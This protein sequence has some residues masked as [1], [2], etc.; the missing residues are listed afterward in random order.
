M[1]FSYAPFSI[2]C[3]QSLKLHIVEVIK[4]FAFPLAFAQAYGINCPIFC[5]NDPLA[6]SVEICPLPRFA[7]K[8]GVALSIQ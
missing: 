2:R 8:Q 1:T 5:V 6:A 3:G 4:Q 7:V